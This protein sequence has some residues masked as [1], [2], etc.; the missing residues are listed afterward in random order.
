MLIYPCLGI[1]WLSGQHG[2]VIDNLV[3]ATL[4]NVNGTILTVNE[5]SNSEL[6]WALRGAGSNFGVVVEF[7]YRLHDQPNKV[8]AGPLV[9]LPS[10]LPELVT[11][12]MKWHELQEAKAGA[13]LSFNRCPEGKVSVLVSLTSLLGAQ[14]T[15]RNL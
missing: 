8:T 9:F 4:V 3:Q 6:F 14:L 2:L 1:G 12:A 15:S 11:A 10:K 5:T 13:L 7:V